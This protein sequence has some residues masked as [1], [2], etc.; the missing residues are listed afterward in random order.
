MTVSEV[1]GRVSAVSLVGRLDAAGADAVSLRFTAA[2]AGAGRAAIVDLSGVSFI[3]SM[4]MRLL[5]SAARALHQKGSA[6]ALY[7]A[8]ENVAAALTDAAL[9]QIIPLVADREQALARVAS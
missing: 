3:A 9:D 7:G 6:L 1:E 2:V 5:V 4:G 8:N